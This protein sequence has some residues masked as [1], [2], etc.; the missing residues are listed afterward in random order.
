M[1]EELSADVGD[2]HAV[3]KTVCEWH[4]SAGTDAHTGCPLTPALLLAG[5]C[6]CCCCPLYEHSGCMW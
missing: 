6:C 1:I 5:R 4:P 2:G 3:V